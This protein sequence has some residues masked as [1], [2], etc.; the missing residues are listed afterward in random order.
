MQIKTEWGKGILV[1]MPEQRI[2]GSNATKF[3]DT[4]SLAIKDT[5]GSLL[6]DMERLTYVSSA[7]LRVILIASKTLESRDMK[8]LVCSLSDKVRRIFQISGI[9]K[10]VET[11]KAREEAIASLSG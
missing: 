5:D 4:L 6:L 7:G 9:D 1:V 2:D 10:M 3:H 8:L 11:H